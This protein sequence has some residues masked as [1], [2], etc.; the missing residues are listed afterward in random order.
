MLDKS[1]QP[2]GSKTKWGILKSI[3][4]FNTLFH[5]MISKLAVFSQRDMMISH[6]TRILSELE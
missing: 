1:L 2:N 6:K 3:L 4:T 5:L